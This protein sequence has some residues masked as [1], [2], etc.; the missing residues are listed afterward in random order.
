MSAHKMQL[1]L[2]GNTDNSNTMKF[3]FL[4]SLDAD[5]DTARG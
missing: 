4:E 5:K 2:L 3:V 1:G